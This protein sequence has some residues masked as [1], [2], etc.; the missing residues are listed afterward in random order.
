MPGTIFPKR[1]PASARARNGQVALLREE[2]AG[3]AK[4]I[5][6]DSRRDNR[7]NFLLADEPGFGVR[8]PG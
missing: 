4:P 5:P 1:L 7:R 2:Q 3:V 8:R 6:D